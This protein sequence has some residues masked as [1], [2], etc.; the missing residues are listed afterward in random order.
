MKS[1]FFSLYVAE[2]MERG[3]DVVLGLSALS[4]R[5]QRLIESWCFWPLPN[6]MTIV[7][8]RKVALNEFRWK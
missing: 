8:A 6:K 1:Q 5:V 7:L 4:C 2:N 3:C